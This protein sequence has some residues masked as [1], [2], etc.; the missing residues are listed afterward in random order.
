WTEDG[1]PDQ[2][3]EVKDAGVRVRK[4]DVAWIGSGYEF[5]L[6]GAKEAYEGI[7][8]NSDARGFVWM[9]DGWSGAQRYAVQWTGDQSG[10]WDNIRFHIPTIAGSGLSGQAFT[11][12]DIDGIFGGSAETYTRDLQ[13]KAF[14]P[15]LM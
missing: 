1:L 11:T 2:E 7:E 6:N 9:V 14:N 10:S 8:E 15:V 13:W 5:A 3:F 4:L 12:G